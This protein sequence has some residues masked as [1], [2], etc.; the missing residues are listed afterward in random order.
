MKTAKFI[1]P[2]FMSLLFLTGTTM[3][4][5]VDEHIEIVSMGA[6]DKKIIENI[7]DKLSAS[8]PMA[9][10]V[11]IGQQKEVPKDAYDAS[12]GQYNALIIVDDVA[13]YTGIDLSNERV[14]IVTN[15]DLYIPDK[16]FVFG[17]AD[18]K[19]GVCVISTTRLNNE[20]IAK[21]AVYELGNSWGLENCPSRKC[22]MHLADN[23]QGIDEKEI[24]FCRNCRDKLHRRYT[25]P[26]FDASLKPLL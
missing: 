6:I 25:K 12:R 4:K 16:E 15:I 5:T 24:T 18:A 1:I 23:I 20:R 26:F 22:V 2:A 13:F 9:A 14:L 11:R 8:L 19:K 3:A 21:E 17:F 7:K 10:S